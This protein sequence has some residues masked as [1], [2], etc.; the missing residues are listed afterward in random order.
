MYLQPGSGN[1]TLIHCLYSNNLVIV[2]KVTFEPWGD[3]DRV[4]DG[5]ERV[6][7]SLLDTVSS[8]H[9]VLSNSIASPTDSCTGDN[10]FHH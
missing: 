4:D 6:G 3:R 8:L 9:Q 10:V 5:K 1:I 2:G 7:A